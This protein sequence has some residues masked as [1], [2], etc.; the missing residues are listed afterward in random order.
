MSKGLPVGTVVML[1]EREILGGENAVGDLAEITED[2]PDY[3]EYSVTLLTGPSVGSEGYLVPYEMCRPA[4]PL[5]TPPKFG[6]VDEAEAW[7]EATYG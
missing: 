3:D 2:R 6:S 7:I 5:P 4:L 1:T